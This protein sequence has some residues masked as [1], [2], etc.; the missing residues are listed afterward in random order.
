MSCVY[1]LYIVHVV[2]LCI[3]ER[4][5][6][7]E[8]DIMYQWAPIVLSYVDA[9]NNLTK[10]SSAHALS[11]SSS[12]SGMAITSSLAGQKRMKTEA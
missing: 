7:K 11:S 12:S 1:V 5:E 4:W 6:E 8:G 10:E 2:D 9:Y 3:T